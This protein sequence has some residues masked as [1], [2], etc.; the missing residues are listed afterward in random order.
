V[1]LGRRL[2]GQASAPPVFVAISRMVVE[3]AKRPMRMLRF[4]MMGLP[5]RRWE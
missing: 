3:K 4:M 5:I 2:V 1:T